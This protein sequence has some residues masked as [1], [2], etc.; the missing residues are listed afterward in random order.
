M[1]AAFLIMRREL[2]AYFRSMTGYIIAA[3]V[4]VIDGIMF[5]AFALGGPDKRSGDVLVAFFYISSGT[6]MIASIF[7]SMRLL[8]EEKQNGTLVLL[9]SSPIR[10]RDI[11]IGK[12]LSGWIFLSLITLSTAFMPGLIMVHGKISFGHLATGYL[13]LLLLGGA[14]MAI[15]TFG[16]AI[17][18]SQVIAAI[19]S[20][21]LVVSLII[22][23]LLA[24]VTEHPLSKI[25]ESLAL[26]HRHFPPFQVGIIHL[27][28]VVYYLALTY[29]A[30][31]GAT[32]VLEAR[33]WK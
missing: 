12:Y 23:W 31:F 13:G 9:T 21:G 26:Y 27:R 19:I 4:L 20:A 15:G 11:V 30:L 6:T 2:G 29:F 25:F 1:S 10:D 3:A 8:A 7:L 17:A 24:R 14:A 5:N 18:K 22:A 16:S 28:D 32:R 33:R